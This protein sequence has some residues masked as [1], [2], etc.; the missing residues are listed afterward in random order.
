VPAHW[1]RSKTSAYNCILVE[2]VY[3]L[4]LLPLNIDNPT[5]RLS[6]FE[7]AFSDIFVHYTGTLLGEAMDT[8]VDNIIG[9]LSIEQ[10]GI[11]FDEVSPAIKALSDDPPLKKE[12]TRKLLSKIKNNHPLRQFN[13]MLSTYL[14]PLHA[15][16]GEPRLTTIYKCLGTSKGIL[17]EKIQNQSG[18]GQIPVKIETNKQS[19]SPPKTKIPENQNT[20]TQK[21]KIP[22]NQNTITQKTKIPENQNTTVQKLKLPENQN[23]TA[24]ITKTK[25]PE[26][27]NTTVTKTNTEEISP[28]EE[29]STC[30]SNEDPNPTNK[31]RK[32][33]VDE[34]LDRAM[35]T[36]ILTQ[37]KKE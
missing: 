21:T 11:I 33:S 18:I 14:Q 25:V 5:Q 8:S 10:Q 26:K 37:K 30:E 32:R 3:Q 27:Q 16:Y 4:L 28:F 19:N 20:T 23:T 13:E 1:D 9:E 22:E 15:A 12:H 17:P 35:E 31:K 36:D 29:E 7:D 6:K 24:Q 34:L 2:L